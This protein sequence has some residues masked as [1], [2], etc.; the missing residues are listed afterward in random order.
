[1][2]LI[3]WPPKI[4]LIFTAIVLA[5]P[6]AAAAE[7]TTLNVEL[8]DMTAITGMQTSDPQDVLG[9]GLMG[10]HDT[11][12]R[13]I[14]TPQ[15]MPEQQWVPGRQWQPGQQGMPWKHEV[16]EQQG[17]MGMISMSVIVDKS[18]LKAGDVRFVVTNM[19]TSLPHE[20]LVVAIDA[21]ATELSYDQLTARIEEDKIHS[22]G[23]VNEL[24]PGMS[25]NLNLNL[26]AGTYLLIC[27]IPGH[28]AAG[29]FATLTV[30]P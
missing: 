15:G 6:L 18:K 2:N 26:K 29:M 11:Q 4:I 1:M 25:G 7:R 5:T 13:V 28:Y 12:G 19:S 9:E 20:L 17:R 8:R 22:L 21:A 27:N 16:P 10:P 14:T 23:K 3:K 24:A 30:I